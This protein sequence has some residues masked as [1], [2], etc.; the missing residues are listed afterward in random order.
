MNTVILLGS[1]LLSAVQPSMPV[2][3]S[4]VTLRH[5]IYRDSRVN[6]YLLDIPPGGATQLH[7]HDRD[8]LSVFVAGGKTRSVFNGAAPVDDT[9]AVG[10]VRFRNAGFTHSTENRDSA[11]FLCVIF[12]FVTSQGPRTA[13]PGQATRTCAA[14]EERC[15]E[16]KPMFCTDGFCV[17]DVVI[18]PYSVKQERGAM[19]DRMLIAVSE[20]SLSNESESVHATTYVGKT[21][22]I[23]LIP[24]GPARRWTNMTGN[25]AHYIV[26]TFR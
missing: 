7:R 20:Y 17:D 1:L 3:A 10:D 11:D 21:G 8:I 15:V 5:E 4:E 18:G 2:P 9:F 16:E 13:A 26:V 25:P 19:T 23:Q 6:V 14:S 12:E 24:A 22:Q